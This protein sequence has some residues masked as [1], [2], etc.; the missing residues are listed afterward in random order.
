[1]CTVRFLR[2]CRHILILSYILFTIMLGINVYGSVYPNIL[3]LS[4]IL[5]TIMLG[6]NVYGSVYL[7]LILSYILFTIML[8]IKC[9][10]VIRFILILILSYILFTIMLGINVYGSVYPYPYP[11][12]YIVHNYARNKCVRFGL[13]LS[14]SYPIY[15]SQLCS[16]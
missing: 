7:I 15:C 16:E 1:M 6:I 2:V 12:L 5:F 3:I 8:G 11:I 10:T 9:G 4:Y 14:L 13:S